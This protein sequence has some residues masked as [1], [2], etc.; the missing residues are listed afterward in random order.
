VKR[1]DL[2]KTGGELVLKGKLGIDFL[3]VNKYIFSGID[4]N[5]EFYQNTHCF[6]LLANNAKYKVNIT[7]MFLIVKYIKL[8]PEIIMA[9]TQ[10]FDSSRNNKAHSPYNKTSIRV[11]TVPK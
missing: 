2:S 9:H 6:R 1:H 10:R 7:S 3:E 4:I 5:L 11:I 8:R